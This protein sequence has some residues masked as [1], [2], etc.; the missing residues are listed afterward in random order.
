MVVVSKTD[1]LTLILLISDNMATI[2]CFDIPAGVSWADFFEDTET[3][4][5]SA[6][7]TVVADEE[8]WEEVAPKKETFVRP[9]KWCKHGNA[10][11]WRNCPFRHE[12]CE[13]HDRWV[14]SGKK[15]RGCRCLVTDPDS[16]KSPEEGGCKYD[17]RDLTKLRT[18]HKSVPASNEAQIWDSFYELGLEAVMPTIYDTTGMDKFNRMLLIRSLEASEIQFDEYETWMQIYAE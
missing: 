3:V 8:G 11:L 18:Y 13:H 17:H 15:T 6:P 4:V 7:E 5:S 2:L 10:C 12:R 1:S 16:K 9:P 14:A